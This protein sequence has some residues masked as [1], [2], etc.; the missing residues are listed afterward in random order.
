M[1]KDL[2]TYD[3]KNNL[4]RLTD[5]CP[6]VSSVEEMMD[7]LSRAHDLYI[8][9]EASS[10]V[11]LSRLVPE[12][13]VEVSRH[14]VNAMGWRDKREKHLE[15][16]RT[17]AD[18]GYADM[19]RE[20]RVT[21][22]GTMID[23]FLPALEKLGAEIKTALDAGDSST[24]RRLAESLTHIANP[25]MTSAAVD[26]KV[27]ELSRKDVT[28]GVKSGKQPWINV[29]TTGP[30]TMQAGEEKPKPEQGE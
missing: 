11:H 5:R 10:A 22:A 17:A 28:E 30:V 8:S 15:E 21:V 16:L 9:G 26:G 12:L 29:T 19:I 24:V 18:I 2:A 13:P 6:D 20:R 1:S 23:T 3:P 25:V 14:L 27:P 4:L 7:V